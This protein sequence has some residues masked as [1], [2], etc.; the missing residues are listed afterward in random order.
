[1][2][3]SL[4]QNDTNS[5]HNTILDDSPPSTNDKQT[6]NTLASPCSR[7]SISGNRNPPSITIL[8]TLESTQI[9]PAKTLWPSSLS[10]HVGS[11]HHYKY[12][13]M[14]KSNVS[15]PSFDRPDQG[16]ARE[17]SPPTTLG[18]HGISSAT[19]PTLSTNLTHPKE[20]SIVHSFGLASDL[21]TPT[22]PRIPVSYR[23]TSIASTLSSDSYT[24]VSSNPSSQQMFPVHS[25]VMSLYTGPMMLAPNTPSPP[26]RYRK[27]RQQARPNL[28][29][30]IQRSGGQNKHF[31]KY[32]YCGWNFKRYEHLKRHML[33]HTGERS[34][35]CEFAGCGKAFSRS[36]NFAAHY[37]THSKK[38]LLQR[39][40]ATA[41]RVDGENGNNSDS[42]T[43]QHPPRM[44]PEMLKLNLNS[45]DHDDYH[46]T[47]TLNH[48]EGNQGREEVSS[49][50][51]MKHICIV[52]N[53]LKRF[54]RLEHLK[55]HQR[56]HTLERPFECS[57]AGCRK[58]FSR[59]DNLAQH[60]KIHQRQISRGALRA[61][62]GMP[63]I[64]TELPY[65]QQQQHGSEQWIKGV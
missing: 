45:P 56:T 22:S 34:H 9:S 37:K 21:I 57:F 6:Q 36:D 28:S 29:T 8:P 10:A 25:D 7:R 55:R 59:S 3:S 64:E 53:C 48:F 35:V 62:A 47:E 61:R 1:M 46:F 15:V 17:Y 14:Y 65:K 11:F 50:K 41:K 18:M 33:V 42:I 32:P 44:I 54:K 26:S 5:H 52:P 60:I 20:L 51:L 24:S 49:S 2:S 63:P 12:M 58:T 31:C 13:P 43:A 40:L 16:T 38:T 19:F 39:R 30:A 27:R 4:I 23:R